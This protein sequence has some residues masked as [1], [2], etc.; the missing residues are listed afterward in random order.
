MEAF[1]GVGGVAFGQDRAPAWRVG[2]QVRSVI[3]EH[4]SMIVEDSRVVTTLGDH[5]RML[6][7][8]HVA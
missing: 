1:E 4:V 8:S 2:R 3:V 6:P 7:G 5:G